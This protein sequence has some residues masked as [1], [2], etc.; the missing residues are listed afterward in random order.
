[1][2]IITLSFV[3]LLLA[4]PPAYAETTSCNGTL[5]TSPGSVSGSCFQGNCS[6]FWGGTFANGTLFCGDGSQAFVSGSISGG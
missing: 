3:L 1:M 4:L 2:R 6:A 5:F